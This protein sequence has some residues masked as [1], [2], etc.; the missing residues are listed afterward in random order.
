MVQK[1]GTVLLRLSS[2]IVSSTRA[3]T[4]INKT[5]TLDYWTAFLQCHFLKPLA[6]TKKDSASLSED[7][8]RKF[9]HFSTMS[10]FLFST[11]FSFAAP[12][13]STDFWWTHFLIFVWPI[14]LFHLEPL[15]DL[16]HFHVSY[17]FGK[18]SII[19]CLA[20]H[21]PRNTCLLRERV[22]VLW[23]K[24]DSQNRIEGC[25]NKLHFLVSLPLLKYILKNS[26]ECTRRMPYQVLELGK[27]WEARTKGLH[28]GPQ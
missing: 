25:K 1:S 5:H 12:S 3:E 11:R 2:F 23:V 8:R 20:C 26:T 16:L 22:C 6:A 10:C 24:T 4:K 7:T 14:K 17:Q 18:S 13:F 21:S 9:T 27:Q 28:S 19:L 15:V